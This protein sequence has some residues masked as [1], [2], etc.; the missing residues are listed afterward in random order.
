MKQARTLLPRAIQLFCAA[1]CLLLIGASRA[2]SLID[3][4]ALRGRVIYL[5]FWA[6]W[7]V[8][9]RQSFP[10]MQEMKEAYEQRGLTIVAINL[11]RDRKDADRFLASFH[12]SFELR[13]D[14][15]GESAE[16]FKVQGM[17]MSML[18]DRRG[19]LRFTHVGFRP[20]DRAAYEDQLRELLAEK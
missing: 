12:P 13:F 2:D 8:P 9:C 18:I 10:W 16:H 3:L 19:E 15:K 17:P 14:P 11:D 20:V 1:G 4:G 7:C 6:S 5:D